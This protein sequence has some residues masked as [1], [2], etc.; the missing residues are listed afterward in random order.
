M[1]RIFNKIKYIFLKLL[2]FLPKKLNTRIMYFYFFRKPISLKNP[3]SFYEKLN[4]LKLNTYRGN[5]LVTNCSDKYLVRNFIKDKGYE[6]ILN[7]LLYVWDTPKDIDFSSLPQKFVIKCNHSSASNLICKDKSKLDI[8]HAKSLINLWYKKDYWKG[9]LEY[10]YEHIERKIICE[11]YLNDG[12]QVLTDYKVYCF[13][14]RPHIIMVCKDIQSKRRYLM[15]DENWLPKPYCTD[16]LDQSYAKDYPKPV[17]L[18]EMLNIAKDLSSDFPFVRVD[19][20]YV[21]EKI[22]FSEMTFVP[23]GGFESE[24]LHDVY[25]KLGQMIILPK[26]KKV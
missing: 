16:S 18:D 4:W 19:F 6:H 26:N 23:S 10:Q 11:K 12:N 1:K 21:D 13:N 9:R 22:I 24:R 25:D 17:F 14:G 8:N 5:Q 2:Y 3:K 7:E 15:F 20:F